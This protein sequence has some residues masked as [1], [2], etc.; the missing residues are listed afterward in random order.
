V[1]EVVSSW[2]FMLT[3]FGIGTLLVYVADSRQDDRIDNLQARVA[4]LEHPAG[5]SS[6]A[7]RLV[8]VRS[9]RMF[10]VTQPAHRTGCK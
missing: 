1:S 9:G 4:C 3:L 6:I 8:S 5:A 7:G 2:P 10:V